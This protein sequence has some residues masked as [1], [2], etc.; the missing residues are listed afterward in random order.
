M[1]WRGQNALCA[2]PFLSLVLYCSVV[3]SV[4]SEMNHG[5]SSLHIPAISGF[6]IASDSGLSVGES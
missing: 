5:H 1:N 3:M 6:V 4:V 2:M